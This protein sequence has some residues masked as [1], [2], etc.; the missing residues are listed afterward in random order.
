MN[1]TSQLWITELIHDSTKRNVLSSAFTFFPIAMTEHYLIMPH[2]VV[3]IY[4]DE[5][6]SFVTMGCVHCVVY[7]VGSCG[8][9]FIY[10]IKQK[11]FYFLRLDRSLFSCFKRLASSRQEKVQNEKNWGAIKEFGL[12]SILHSVK[13][14]LHWQV[15]TAG[16]PISF[17]IVVNWF[18][19][20]ITD[21]PPSLRDIFVRIFV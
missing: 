9:L 8:E 19:T 10:L 17:K 6:L 16:S 20:R 5:I 15:I 7:F 11:G 21:A 12:E 3:R 13:I 14:K 18:I 1:F 4:S 2:C